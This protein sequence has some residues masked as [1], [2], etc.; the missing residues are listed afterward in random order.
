MQAIGN[1]GPQNKR[2][3]PGQNVAADREPILVWLD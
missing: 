1:H 3:G 2:P